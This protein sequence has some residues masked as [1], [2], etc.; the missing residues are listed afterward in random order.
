MIT[1]SS[2]MS[3]LAPVSATISRIT[4]PPVPM[5][6]RIF[7]LSI[8]IVSIRGAWAES[9]SRV[10]SSALAISP[11]MW[12]RPSFAWASAAFMISSVMPAI[13]MS[14]CSEVMPSLVPATLKSMSPR[15]SSSP[16]MS[17]STAKSLPSRIRPMAMPETGALQRHARVHHRERAAADRRHRRRAVG[18]GDV[19]EDRGSYRGT[20][21]GVG[22][23][24]LSARQAS[25]PWPTSRRAGRAEA[26]DFADRIR[27]EVVVQHE[28]LVGE[29]GQAVDHLLG[30]LGAERGRA[31]RL[32]LAAGE[33]R[34]AV[35]ARQEA[36][37][38]LDR[39][40]RLGV[41]AVDALAVLEDRA[42]D[43]VRL[44]LLHQ[45]QACRDIPRDRSCST[46]AKASR[47]LVRASLIAFWRSDL[48][49]S[50]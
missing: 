1:P 14:I 10:W 33:Q 15:W 25:L 6:S 43:D 26:A 4:L 16:R 45:L 39:A 40:D 5:T 42:A 31:D 8:C 50:L 30:F 3:T 35:G 22:S 17:L 32:G 36:D 13:L 12:A 7:A 44:E 37:D 47:A 29:A 34:R 2:S 49:V 19:G 28:A 27:R 9:S 46:S 20:P 48:L 41:A 38:R 21:P 23:T 11:R 18:L 24:P